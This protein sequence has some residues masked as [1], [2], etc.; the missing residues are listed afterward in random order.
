MGSALVQ[1]QYCRP[2]GRAGLI[3]IDNRCALSGDSRPGNTVFPITIGRQ[4][5]PTS[6]A[7]CLPEYFRVLFGPAGVIRKIGAECHNLFGHKLAFEV[8]NQRF[9]ALGAIIDG[10]QEISIHFFLS[11]RIVGI[12]YPGLFSDF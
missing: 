4:Q 9:Q 5:P 12:F 11:V 1:P 6:L 8:E 2:E 3:D 10:Q 7:E